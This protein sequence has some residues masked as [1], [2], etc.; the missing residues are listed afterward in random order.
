MRL[1]LYGTLAE[2]A[3][4]GR[5]A[6]RPLVGSPAPAMLT[7]Y[8]RVLLRGGEVSNPAAGTWA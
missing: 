2:P 4:L 8:R 3:G 5:C 6:G 1:F 7:G